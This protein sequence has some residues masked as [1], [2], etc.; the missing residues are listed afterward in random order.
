VFPHI[1][2][3]R[4]PRSIAIQTQNLGNVG[5]VPQRGKID[6]SPSQA[7][8]IGA[9]IK[10][11]RLAG[12]EDK[13]FRKRSTFSETHQLLS[14]DRIVAAQRDERK[15]PLNCAMGHQGGTE[16]ERAYR[17]PDVLDKRRELM[18]AWARFCSG[19]GEGKIVQLVDRRK[20]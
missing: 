11:D 5:N 20:A 6:N 8:R 17:G 4:S 15:V 2:K 13:L 3:H 7:L 18:D 9:S 1:K 10:K 19:N 14:E 12:K 16:V